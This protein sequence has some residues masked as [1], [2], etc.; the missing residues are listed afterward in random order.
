MDMR[1]TAYGREGRYMPDRSGEF[2]AVKRSARLSEAR[3]ARWPLVGHCLMK[4]Q[5]NK[6]PHRHAYGALP[7][8]SSRKAP[9][10]YMVD[11][12]AWCEARDYKTLVN[13]IQVYPWGEG[14]TSAGDSDRGLIGLPGIKVIDEATAELLYRRWCVLRPGEMRNLA[15]R[16]TGEEIWSPL[17]NNVTYEDEHNPTPVAAD[18]GSSSS[19]SKD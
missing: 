2:R 6:E 18:A 7:S 17:V 5:H 15:W 1:T 9:L 3:K 12:L 8:K 14:Y 16:G 4:Y 19:S 10:H 11:Q 13:G